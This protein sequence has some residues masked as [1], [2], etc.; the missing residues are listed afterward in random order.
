[1]STVHRSSPTLEKPASEMYEMPVIH[2]PTLGP[3]ERA[4]VQDSPPFVK[5]WGHGLLRLD[6][7]E[8][9]PQSDDGSECLFI[10]SS[11]AW[12]EILDIL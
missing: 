1:M 6:I 4:Y 3:W 7:A 9:R 11:G 5:Y 12:P 8:P 2:T 10:G